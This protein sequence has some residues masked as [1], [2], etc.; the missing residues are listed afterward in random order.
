MSAPCQVELHVSLGV[1]ISLCLSDLA[2]K[3]STSR[4]GPYSSWHPVIS[5]IAMPNLSRGPRNATESVFEKRT[6]SVVL[7]DSGEK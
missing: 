1:L 6:I 4:T 2:D 5:S 3:P 7:S